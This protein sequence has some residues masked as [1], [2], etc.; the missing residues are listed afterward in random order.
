MRNTDIP[1]LELPPQ[2]RRPEPDECC[3]SGCIPCVYDLYEEELA[4][5]GERCAELRARHQQALDA[6]TD[7]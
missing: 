2:P 4:E 5:W 6:S 1:T 3:G 7:K